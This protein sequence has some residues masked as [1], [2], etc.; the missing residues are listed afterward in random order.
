MD[1]PQL[2]ILCAAIILGSVLGAATLVVL[3]KFFITRFIVRTKKKAAHFVATQGVYLA[4]TASQKAIGF[5]QARKDNAKEKTVNYL[6]DRT[7]TAIRSSI[8]F[9]ADEAREQMKEKVSP[10]K[11]SNIIDLPT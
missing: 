3:A 10:E 2:I 8:D 6:K 11:S 9:V 4:K 7:R 1:W 5:V